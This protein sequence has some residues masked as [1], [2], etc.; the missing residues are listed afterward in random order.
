MCCVFAQLSRLLGQISRVRLTSARIGRKRAPFGS[1][2]EMAQQYIAEIR[3]CFPQ[4][5]YVIVGACTGG[6]VAYEMAQQLVEQD[7]AVTLV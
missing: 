1:V 4:G 2:A 3:T 5:P 6:L 7:G